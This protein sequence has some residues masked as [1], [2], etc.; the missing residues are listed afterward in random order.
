M[1]DTLSNKLQD[2]FKNLRGFGKLSESNIADA[3]REVR[4]AL[5]EA[6][7]NYDVAVQFIDSVK[8]KALGG[9]VL[10][11]VSPGQQIVKVIHDEMVVLLGRAQAPLDL[12]RSTTKILMVGLNGSGKTTTT[13]KLARWLAS[14]GRR[15]LLV[16][17]DVYR[18]AAIQQLQVLGEQVG[19]PVFSLPG[20]MDVAV[21]SKK[22]LDY[23]QLQQRNVILFDT[24]GRFQVDEPLM[25]E[26]ARLREAVNPQEV[27]LVADSATGQ[28]AA[29][30]ALVFDRRV[31]L[32]GF[33]LTKLD[34]DARGGA[35]LSIHAVTH[36]PIKWVGTGE[37]IED[38]E[39][40]HPD[41][42]ASRILGMGDIV[43]LVEK[44]QEA[45][46]MEKAEAL[47]RKF[48]ANEFT[49]QDFL[50]QL[51]A[52]RKMGPL[53]NLLSMIPGAGNIKDLSVGEKDLARIQ[54]IIQSMTKKERN[55]PEILNGRRRLRI[56]KGSG[57][58]VTEVNDLLKRF[59]GM[60]KMMKNMGKMSKMLGQMG[61]M[62]GMGQMP[63]FR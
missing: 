22:A 38:L 51:A 54:A 14:Q 40:F 2:I 32:T 17:C 29:K 18:P 58:S 5:L 12:S 28:E 34:G 57:T 43:S 61:G 3:L 63:F 31:N 6:D 11:S 1:F 7:V 9:E 25:E 33:I 39:P 56:A 52:V 47:E 23:A 42:M 53:E 26:L 4:I 16:A 30:V 15:P 13:A 20:E 59:G 35:A 36:K 8:A 60:R 10:R 50:D 27:L 48:R 44:A 41:R 19:T 45:V 37:K 62:P 46:D 49:L 24:A 21:I 55:H